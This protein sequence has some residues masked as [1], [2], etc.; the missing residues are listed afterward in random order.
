[1]APEYLKELCIL[2]TNERR[3]TMRSADRQDIVR[4][5]TA[6]KFGERAF[7]IAGPAAW[8]LLLVHI[9]DR[10]PRWT[11]SGERGTRFFSRRRI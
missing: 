5:R 6:S 4:K 1:M 10:C 8:N 3:S 11:H 9:C 2:L 7:S